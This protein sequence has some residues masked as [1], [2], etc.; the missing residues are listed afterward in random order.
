M[1][2]LPDPRRYPRVDARD[3]LIRLAMSLLTE[4]DLG[5]LVRK[6]ADLDAELSRLLGAG[7]DAAIGEAL[8]KVPSQ[9]VYLCLNDRLRQAVERPPVDAAGHN[10]LFALPLV[11]VAGSRA[12]LSLPGRLPDPT[13]VLALLREHGIIHPEAE[14]E[15][16][17][18]LPT[19]SQLAGIRPSELARWRDAPTATLPDF[20]EQPLQINGETVL[21]RFIVGVAR[22]P[23]QAAPAVQLGIT[24]GP[25][26][27]ALTRL[28]SE[29][30]KHDNLTLFPL[31]RAP[32]PW[33]PA[34]H[35]GRSARLHIQFEIY[36]SNILRKLRQGGEQPVAVLSAHDNDEL[37]VT[38]GA[39]SN[40]E[41][42]EG[43][44]WP[45]TPLDRVEGIVA[46][47]VE[48]LRECRLDRIEI[49]PEVLPAVHEGLPYFPLPTELD[50]LPL[51]RH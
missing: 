10:V 26:G 21:L 51:T 14:V 44:V 19:E 16:L 39:A 33:L 35:D 13:A 24:P 28:L 7:D 6:E 15:L 42:W 32:L 48:L 41:V 40:G 1:S 23:A 38:L 34:R 31:P 18:Q 30:W 36:A 5:A 47:M 3:S 22:Q 49:L 8:G 25:W 2:H 9:E 50:A 11:L 29:Q 4:R 12:P 20:A 45:L 37:H 43:F 17:A 46:A 27:L